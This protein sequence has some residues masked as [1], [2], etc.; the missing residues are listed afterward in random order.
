M[1]NYEIRNDFPVLRENKIAYLDS[2]ATTQ[3]PIQVLDKVDN[4]YK[5]ENANTHRGAYKPQRYTKMH[6]KKLQT[7]LMHHLQEIL[8]LQEMLLK[9]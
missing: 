7:L 5:S 2:G 6:V 9:A 3:R 4:F 1:T 8:Y